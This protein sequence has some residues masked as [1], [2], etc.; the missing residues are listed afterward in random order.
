MSKIYIAGRMTG[1]P[2]WNIEAFNEAEALL[3]LQGHT[4]LN[5]AKATPMVAPEII[6]HSDYM[7][8]AIAML[9]VCDTIYMLDGW[10]HS[11][12]ALIE[13]EYAL[14][15]CMTIMYQTQPPECFKYDRKGVR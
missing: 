5:P 1:M 9:S 14:D 2:N 13:Y 8:I 6:P 11:K 7:K 3:S 10:Q 12:G 15:H 4:V